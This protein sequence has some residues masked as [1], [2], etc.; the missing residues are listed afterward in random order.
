M[1]LPEVGAALEGSVGNV[2]NLLANPN[3]FDSGVAAE[4]V[5]V[6]AG[7]FLAD[8]HLGLV[9]LCLAPSVLACVDEH[10]ACGLV[11][12][13]NFLLGCRSVLGCYFF[14]FT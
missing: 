7:K 13:G 10:V 6:D 4:L 3:L 8:E 12:L 5:G 14:L 9:G 2:L 1:N 11:G